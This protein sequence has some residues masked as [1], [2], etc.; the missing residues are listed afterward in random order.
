MDNSIIDLIKSLKD[1]HHLDKAN[2]E[3]IEAAEKALNLKF[4]DEYKKYVSEFGVISAVGIE[5]TGV[6]SSPRLSVVEV[7]KREKEV[8]EGIPNNMYVIED[9]GIEGLIILQDQFGMVY[10]IA[11]N[12]EPKKIFNS[13]YEY[14]EY[15]GEFY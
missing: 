10:S 4:S 11:H 8:N 15:Y 7:T 3:E 12:G 1:M 13:L 2:D 14:L 9:T 5:L 6:T